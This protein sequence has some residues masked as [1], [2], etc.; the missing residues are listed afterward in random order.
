MSANPQSFPASPQM[1]KEEAE[2]KLARAARR[3]DALYFSGA[4]LCTMG[5]GMY[6]IRIGLIV[7]GCFLLLIPMIELAASF[8]RGLRPAPTRNR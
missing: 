4:I 6:Q 7:A 5:A 3:S 8:I 2:R 1:K